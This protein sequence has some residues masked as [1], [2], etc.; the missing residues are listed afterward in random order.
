MAGDHLENKWKDELKQKFPQYFNNVKVLD[1]GSADMNGTNKGWFDN[2]E[3]I[4]LDI[5]PYKNVDVVS[6]AHEYNVPDESFDVVCSTSELE[7]DMYWRK[8]LKKMV[9]LLKPNGLMWFSTPSQWSEHGTKTNN[10][11]D[12]LT[13]KLDSEW[14]DYYKNLTIEDI[15]S[16]LD[17]DAIFE[18]H[19]MFYFNDPGHSE[20]SIRFWGIKKPYSLKTYWDTFY[21]PYQHGPRKHRIYL[22]DL[23]KEKGV[24]S[25]FDIGMGTGPIYELIKKSE[26]RWNFDYK[27]TDYSPAMVDV[28]KKTFP[29]GNFEVQDARHLTEPDNSWDSVL[30]MHCLDHLDDYQSAIRE[31]KRVA[32]KYICIVLWRSFVVKGTNINPINRM[33][34]EPDEEPWEDTFLQEYS[35]EVLMEEF[36][37]NNLKVEQETQGDTVNSDEGHYNWLVLLSK[38]D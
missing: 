16:V 37:K 15:K 12:S 29:E 20:V 4:G 14:A 1:I 22:L 23:L 17:L 9:A 24:K 31:A 10:P 3:Y 11:A 2:C 38:N 36:K 34:K 19:E 25:L 21:T 6:I 26:G 32:R 28:A 8:T 30:L 18:K 5:A 13:S 7:H 35:R 27:G 33:G